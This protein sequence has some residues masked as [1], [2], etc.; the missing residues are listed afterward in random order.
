MGWM[1]SAW[2]VCRLDLTSGPDLVHGVGAMGLDLAVQGGW[3]AA[4]HQSSHAGWWGRGV[5]WP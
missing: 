3:D 5:A 1:G 2:S 4:Q